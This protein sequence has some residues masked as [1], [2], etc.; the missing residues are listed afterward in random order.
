[1]RSGSETA[2][3][4][5]T[6]E[7]ALLWMTCRWRTKHVWPAIGQIALYILTLLSPTF[8][9]VQDF[10]GVTSC[11]PLRHSN[12]APEFSVAKHS[13]GKGM[14][15]WQGRSQ[16]PGWICHFISLRFFY[17]FCL[18]HRTTGTIL[19]LKWEE[20]GR[21]IVGFD[22]PFSCHTKGALQFHLIFLFRFQGR[23]KRGGTCGK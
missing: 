8:P 7:L 6:G 1:M 9:G 10:L 15:V 5:P 4:I 11:F 16:T 12:W 21:E 23:E 17:G 14:Y 20:V 18:L 2:E 19:T 3:R 22:L 13:H